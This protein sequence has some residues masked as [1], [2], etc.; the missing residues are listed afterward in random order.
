MLAGCGVKK[1]LIRPSE[2]P[3]YERKRQEKLEKQIIQP[4]QPHAMLQ[5]IGAV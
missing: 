3:E 5:R 2:I 1:P 4:E